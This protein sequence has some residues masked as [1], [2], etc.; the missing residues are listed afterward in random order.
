LR[1]GFLRKEGRKSLLERRGVLEEL[2]TL[3][4][5]GWGRGDW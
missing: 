5:F 1:R 2:R 4:D 3:K